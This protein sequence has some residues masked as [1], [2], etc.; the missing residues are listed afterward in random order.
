MAY[1]RKQG[2][3]R[4]S[5]PSGVRVDYRTEIGRVFVPVGEERGFVVLDPARAALL[6][7]WTSALIPAGGRFPAAGDVGAAEYIDATAFLA[8]RVRGF[9]LDGLRALDSLAARDSGRP[10]VD[11][12]PGGQA[13]ILRL[14]EA[15]D[16]TEVFGMIRELTYEA[17]YAHPRV[18]DVLGS[19]TGW[20]A[21]AANSGS[22]LEEF[23]ESLLARMKK[24][25]PHY[26]KA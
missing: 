10:F 12:D 19:T 14:Y 16:A 7:A 4:V 2:D 24:I 23:D 6:R 13:A 20:R 21:D 18:L 11:C 8:P 17:Y 15:E 25:T 22:T 1:D 3:E 26:R 9:L 5:E